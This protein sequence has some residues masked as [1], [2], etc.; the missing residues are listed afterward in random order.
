M[1]PDN[2][3]SG[4]HP[5]LVVNNIKNHVT[6]ELGMD[7]DQ[8]PLWVIHFT[9][10]AKSNRVLHHIV[11]PTGGSKASST[12]DEKELWETLDATVLQWIYYTVTTDLLET[13]VEADTTAMA[14]WKQIQNIFQD[15]KNSRAVTLEQEFSHIAM[16][17]FPSVSA[18]CHRLKSLAD[19]LKN[20]GSPVS[21]TRLVLQMVS[22]LTDAYRNVGT[23]IRQRDPLPP[24]Y[25]ARSMLTLEEA[26]FSKEA[27]TTSSTALLVQNGGGVGGTS[28]AKSPA[29]NANKNNRGS[30]G[31]KKNGGHKGGKGS[32]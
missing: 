18:Y 22:G 17:D 31:K 1:A 8:Y 5:A 7:N 16:S 15:N 32:K 3:K 4:F 2:T 10:H 27:A 23:I 9:N 26:G 29:T 19:Q 14:T 25:Q 24:F 11:E 28:G 21:E 20:V 30:N 6:V 13:I 12:A